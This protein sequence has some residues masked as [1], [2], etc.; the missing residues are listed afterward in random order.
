[1]SPEAVV[2]QDDQRR[3][4]VAVRG[5]RLPRDADR[6]RQSFRGAGVSQAQVDGVPAALDVAAPAHRACPTSTS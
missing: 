4:N 6:R 2:R 5:R 3:N 1:M